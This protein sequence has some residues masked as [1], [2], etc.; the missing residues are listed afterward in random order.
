M[1]PEG[2]MSQS[3]SASPPTSP[4]TTGGAIEAREV[5]DA[6]GAS[7]RATRHR[8]TM[9]RIAATARTLALVCI[10]RLG[11]RMKPVA[12]DPATEPTVFAR[13]RVPA[14]LPTECSAR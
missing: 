6:A 4:D 11:K 8:G 12:S 1:N 10:P 7:A 5:I 13:Y 14:L 2:S 9:A 3:A